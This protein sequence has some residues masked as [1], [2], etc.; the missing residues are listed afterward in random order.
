MLILALLLFPIT[1]TNS[2]IISS[3]AMPV[4]R[5]MEL[6]MKR[7]LFFQIQ[8]DIQTLLVSDALSIPW[9]VLLLA[10]EENN[11]GVGGSDGE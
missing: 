11:A 2:C 3:D 7:M 4:V 10:S 8:P 6:M 5:F 1:A 9:T